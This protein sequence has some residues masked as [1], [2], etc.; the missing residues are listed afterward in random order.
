[1]SFLADILRVVVIRKRYMRLCRGGRVRA[2]VLVH[3]L[4]CPRREV[5]AKTRRSAPEKS[6][7]GRLHTDHLRPLTS[8]LIN[9]SRDTAHLLLTTST[10]FH[11]RPHRVYT[12][13][14]HKPERN[15]TR[16]KPCGLAVKASRTALH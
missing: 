10:S 13:N 6:G 1:M 7:R 14:P 8:N 15:S 12:D 2:P 5:N 4:V 11:L 16:K 9:V 3:V